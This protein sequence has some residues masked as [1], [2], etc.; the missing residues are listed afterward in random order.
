MLSKIR[1]S[2]QLYLFHACFYKNRKNITK[3]FAYQGTF[4][5]IFIDFFFFFVCVGGG[6]GGGG[7]GKGS[8]SVAAGH[9]M[10]IFVFRK[11][12]KN[13]AEGRGFD[14]CRNR[15]FIKSNRRKK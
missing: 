8:V 13:S 3:V 2:L 4:D 10:S 11:T 9:K 5:W 6:G 15:R 1:H 7:G 12:K 14:I